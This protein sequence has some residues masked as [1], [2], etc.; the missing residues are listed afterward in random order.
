MARQSYK[1]KIFGKPTQGAFDFSD[2]NIIDAPGGKYVL[3]LAMTAS[4]WYPEYRIDDIGIQ[5]DFYIDDT[6]VE[7]DWVE[8]VQTV[9]EQE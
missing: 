7:E 1:V 9:V 2:M 6:I 5:P 8:F 3:G 4:K